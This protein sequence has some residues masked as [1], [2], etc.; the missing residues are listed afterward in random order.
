MPV[1]PHRVE[2][3]TAPRKTARVTQR[4]A[5]PQ[6]ADQLRTALNLLNTKAATAP[7]TILALKQYVGTALDLLL[8]PDPVL[9]RSAFTLLA[10]RQST[11]VETKTIRGRTI[12]RVTIL[13][14]DMYAWSLAEAHRLGDPEYVQNLRGAANAPD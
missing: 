5:D 7:A 8:S 4:G 3:V 14:Q 2:F 10:V 9:E 13:D 6:A 12:N 11:R 1:L